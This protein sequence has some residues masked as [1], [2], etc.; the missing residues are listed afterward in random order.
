[1]EKK[2][3]YFI[4]LT[5]S[6][7][8]PLFL[9]IYTTKQFCLYKIKCILDGSSLYPELNLLVGRPFKLVCNPGV[10]ID[11]AVTIRFP[12]GIIAGTCDPPTSHIPADCSGAVGYISTL[13]AAENTVTISTNSLPSD[14]NGTWTCTHSTDTF[15]YNLVAPIRGTACC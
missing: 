3:Y 11:S 2:A 13:N 1:M 12:D 6:L 9:C 10:T 14:A 8:I 5:F 7:K 15:S 4:D